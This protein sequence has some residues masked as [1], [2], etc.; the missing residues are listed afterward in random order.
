MNLSDAD[1]QSIKD[2]IDRGEPLPAKYKLVLS[3]LKNG[4]LRCETEAAGGD[5]KKG[6]YKI[7]IKA[8]DIFGDDTTKVVEIKV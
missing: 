4:P 7:A 1:K 3:S 5:E 8:I 2:D 6:R